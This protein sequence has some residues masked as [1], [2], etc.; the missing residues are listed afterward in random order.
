MS[1]FSNGYEWD[2]WSDRWCMTCEK[3]SMGQPAAT[4]ERFCP[5]VTDVLAGA[6]PTPAQWTE[7]DPG[8][9]ADRYTCS[10]YQARE[11]EP[12]ATRS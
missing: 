12:D 5:I 1:A 2:C 4:P 9:L 7:V 8:G 10:A 6:G 3:D 11:G